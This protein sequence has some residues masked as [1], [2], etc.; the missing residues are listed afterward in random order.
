MYKERIYIQLCPS[1][2]WY[3]YMWKEWKNYPQGKSACW[4][5]PRT[6]TLLVLYGLGSITQWAMQIIPSCPPDWWPLWWRRLSSEQQ[7][8]N[9][10]YKSMDRKQVIATRAWSGSGTGLAFTW[11][12][13]LA[14]ENPAGLQRHYYDHPH[15]TVG[16][17]EAQWPLCGL[18][19]SC[20]RPRREREGCLGPKFQSLSGIRTLAYKI[21]W[22]CVASR[23]IMSNFAIEDCSLLWL[24]CSWGFQA[25][26]LERVTSP[27]GIFPPRDQ[28]LAPASLHGSGFFTSWSYLG[29][30]TVDDRGIKM[31]NYFTEIS[32]TQRAKKAMSAV[33]K[34]RNLT[35]KF[36]GK[37]LVTEP[38]SVAPSFLHASHNYSCHEGR[39]EGRMYKLDLAT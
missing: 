4:V 15:F 7:L 14:W 17:T 8:G 2:H 29:I 9:S 3:R 13:K 33:M 35:Q 31:K 16:K 21:H 6:G 36:P 25:R 22:W 5:M 11:I 1:D 37:Q 24:I 12:D 19:W 20:P 34:G 23:S 38:A 39:R 28:T 32:R 26:I 10:S 18:Q 27:K 30:P